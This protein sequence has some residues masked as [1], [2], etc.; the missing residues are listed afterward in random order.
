M[1][2]QFNFLKEIE[3]IGEK[4]KQNFKCCIGRFIFMNF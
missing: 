4:T 2:L 1:K 3:S